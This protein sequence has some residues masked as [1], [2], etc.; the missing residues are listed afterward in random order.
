MKKITENALL[1]RVNQLREKM[2]VYEA[3]NAWDGSGGN[4]TA[5][6]PNSANISAP[7]T[8]TN[9]NAQTSPANNGYKPL[10]SFTTPNTQSQ[11]PLDAQKTNAIQHPTNFTL[12]A[13]NTTTPAAPEGH[14]YDPAVNFAKRVGD[15]LSYAADHADELGQGVGQT[16]A[17][18]AKTVGNAAGVAG[19]FIG[20]AVKGA[21]GGGDTQGQQKVG[22]NQGTQPGGK[23]PATPAEIQAFQKANGLKVDGLIGA[24]TMAALQKQG[25]QPPAGFKPVANRQHP[26]APAG[27]AAKPVAGSKPVAGAAPVAGQVM[28]NGSVSSGDADRDERLAQFGQVA[29]MTPDQQHSFYMGTAAQDAKSAG[30]PMDPASVARA[31]QPYGTTPAPAANK[32][33]V[34]GQMQSTGDPVKDSE[35]AKQGNTIVYKEDQDLARIVQ[36]ARW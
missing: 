34:G 36:L 32:A 12:Q 21:M 8:P 9:T 7:V 31:A 29:Q 35:L 25:V 5:N 33:P 1:Y 17:N 30:H 3:E 24:N 19:N 13:G 26:A 4:K 2:A 10:S 15:D 16:A 22:A 20:G 23:W 28:P 14:F 18:M 6:P 27:T 11:T